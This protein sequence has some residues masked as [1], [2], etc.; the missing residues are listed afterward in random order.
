M[1][2]VVW[3]AW[4]NW[5]LLHLGPLRLLDRLVV[6]VGIKYLSVLGAKLRLA[7][8]VI[9]HAGDDSA[10]SSA[11][12]A[13]RDKTVIESGDYDVGDDGAGESWD[14]AADLL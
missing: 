3:V 1:E 12:E 9:R 4:V 7:E 5:L 2:D 8:E 13:V 14:C 10:D 6:E 11:D